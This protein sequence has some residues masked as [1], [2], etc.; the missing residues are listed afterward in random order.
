[1]DQFRLTNL[2]RASLQE[3]DDDPLTDQ[4]Q[5]LRSAFLSFRERAAMLAGEI[6]QDLKDFTVHDIAHLDA[7][8]ETADLICGDEVQLNPLEVFVLGGAFLVHD[9]GMSLA[10]FPN[11]KDVV[12][13]NPVW[14]DR[15][16]SLLQEKVGRRPTEVEIE[17][18]DEDVKKSATALTLRLLH[19]EQAEKLALL[20][21][22]HKGQ[23]YHLIEDTDIRLHLGPLIG[24]IAHS[25]W[26]PPSR[27]SQEFQATIGAASWCPSDWTIDSL[28]IACVLRLADASNLD[29]RRAP[30]FL[31]TLRKPAD[32]AD[33]HWAFQGILQKPRREYDRLIFTS[34][35]PFKLEDAPAWWLCWETLQ[36][37]DR[38]LRQVDALLA[39]TGRRR[40]AVRG[41]AGADDPSR[42]AKYVRTEGWIPVTARIHVSNVR[43]LIK[44]LGGEEL[45]GN[46]KYVCIRELIQNACDAVRARRYVDNRESNWGHVVVSIGHTNGKYW[47]E[48]ED[49]GIGMS[50][51]VLTGPFLDFGTSYWGSPLMSS[52]F[53]GLLAKGF[54]S[55]G[56]YGIGFFSVFM[57]GAHVT[58]TTRRF[59]HAFSSTKV[60]E[61]G[62]GL[63]APPT[64]RTATDGEVLREG[65]TRVRVE[66]SQAPDS[67]NGL[68][69]NEN[70][71]RVF[72]LDQLL[73]WLCPASDVDIYTDKHKNR[74]LIKTNDWQTIPPRA[75]LSRT[76]LV[77]PWDRKAFDVFARKIGPNLRL[78]S[79]SSGELAGRI[80][81]L[82]SAFRWSTRSVTLGGVVTVGGLRASSLDG[83][84]GILTG[85]PTSASRGSSIPFA[86][87]EDIREWATGQSALQGHLLRDERAR[88]DAAST[89]I[90]CGGDIGGLTVAYSQQG[91]LNTEKLRKFVAQRSK[92]RVA[93]FYRFEEWDL[94]ADVAL[95]DDVLLMPTQKY[96]IVY[97]DEM[98]WSDCYRCMFTGRRGLITSKR[99]STW[100]F[101]GISRSIL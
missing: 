79:R 76:H 91:W 39:D 51:E 8:W 67:Q 66:L 95:D 18:A 49:N 96:R 41:V 78:V 27:L 89:I 24:R 32:V 1:M 57:L 7:L 36:M 38:E 70:Q 4:R 45:Y 90:A 12:A 6:P 5:R 68:L 98:S 71:R 30:A 17:H 50:Q 77:P 88:T 25:H 11:G 61:F 40:F 58:I 60:L 73:P 74:P 28:K 54:Q 23:T 97:G 34:S 43:D 83:I 63:D 62:T 14:R 46:R 86:Q 92:I 101:L 72:P 84:A 26:W 9:L 99:G 3:R 37:V 42:L 55:T 100:R 29:A 81:I 48:V 94:T 69:W 44:K 21:F 15:V 75:L 59:E 87:L 19:A 52:E 2:W 31:R 65:G 22:S 16:V 47:L 13:K 82:P 93:N 80:A 33:R 20:S 53:P 56:R 35:R 85:R 10:A 64:L